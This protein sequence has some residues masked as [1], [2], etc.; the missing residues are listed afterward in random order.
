MKKFDVKDHEPSFLPEGEWKLV[1]SLAT[2]FLTRFGA[3]ITSV[4]QE[5][6][7]FT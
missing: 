7:T 6:L 3:L 1:W 2:S 4:T 5:P